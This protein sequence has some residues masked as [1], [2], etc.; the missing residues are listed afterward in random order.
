M[1]KKKNNKPQPLFELKKIH[2]LT[3]TQEHTFR[4][5][6]S[7]KNLML[8]GYPGT[9]KTYVSL[10]LAL[11]DVFL[12]TPKYDKIMV[13]R[14]IVPSRDIGFLPGSVK[15]K[16]RV[17]EEPYKE[18]CDSLFGRGDGYEILKMKNLVD[19]TTTSF[20]RGKTFNNTVVIVDEMQNM[21]GQELDTIMTRMGDNS[22]II[23]C[24]DFRQSDLT[25]KEKAGLF[26]FINITKRMNCF[27]YIEFHKDD[28]V[29]SA[30]VKEYI[31]A[32]TEYQD[33]KK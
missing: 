16:A 3:K 28:I 2:P 17:Y 24:G 19:F 26:E 20:L 25:D 6:Y 9:G 11:K 22:K 30:L 29:R 27:E 5:Y 15:E 10:Y 14:S 33:G 13:I 1:S 8:H 31:I 23:F 4:S 7:D 21:S 12:P 32:K 18:I